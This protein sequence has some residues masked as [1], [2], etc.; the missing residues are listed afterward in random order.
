MAPLQKPPKIAA[1]EHPLL[2]E[3]IADSIRSAILDGRLEPGERLTEP[4][5]SRLLGVSRTPVREAFFQLISEGF[6]E[7]APRRGVVVAALSQEDAEETYLLKG[8]L[9]ALA[10][11]LAVRNAP[12]GLADEL[13]AVNAD[14]QVAVEATPPDVGRILALNDRFH[15]TLTEASGKAKL[16][17]LVMLYRRQTLRYNYIYMSALSR[18]RHSVE[19]H[20]AIIAAFRRKDGEELARLVR[21][22]NEAALKAL[23]TFM[24]S[25]ASAAQGP[26]SIP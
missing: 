21:L 6:V 10:A 16:S 15:R 13:D 11:T 4:E 8:T 25:P 22:H 9:E 3:G 19:E 23:R 26:R 1:T 7:A 2:R 12:P 20:R 17:R 18:L 24:A 5:V 14:L